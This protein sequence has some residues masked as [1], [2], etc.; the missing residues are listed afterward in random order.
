M[1]VY[2]TTN[3]RSDSFAVC[4]NLREETMAADG[5]TVSN[6]TD[7]AGFMKYELQQLDEMMDQSLNHPAIMTWAWFK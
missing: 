5:S 7:W 2:L 1:A 4:A 3:K 6:L